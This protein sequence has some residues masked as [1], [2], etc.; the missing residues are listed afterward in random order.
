MTSHAPTRIVLVVDDAEDCIATLDLALQALPGVEIMP[1][2]TAEAALAMLTRE[3]ISAVIT[4]LQLPG[5]NGLE[6]IA[7]IRKQPKFNALPIVAVS[8]ATDP[9]APQAALDSGADAF[10]AKPFSPSAIR[11]KVEELL[12]ANSR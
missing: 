3:T 12:Y 4:D 10:F 8:A 7:S 5:M 2:E 1:A 9:S 11:K 6:M